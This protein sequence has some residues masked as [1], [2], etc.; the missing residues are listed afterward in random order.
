MDIS[1][2]NA[3]RALVV[4]D[5]HGNLFAWE[6][7][8]LPAFKQSHAD[9]ILQ[10]GDFGYGWDDYYLPRLDELLDEA[11]VEVL[12]LDG[13][14]ENFDR[15]EAIGAFP[16]QTEPQATSRHT[17][18]LPRGFVWTWHGVRCMALGG[19]YSVD[20]D[21][22]TPHRSWWPQEELTDEDVGRACAQGIVQVMFTHDAPFGVQ[23]PG[24]PGPAEE[25]R[26]RELCAPNRTKVRDVQE[27]MMPKTLFAGH[28]HVPYEQRGL[29]NSWVVGLSH[30]DTRGSTAIIDFADGA[31][32]WERI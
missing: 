29:R 8:I 23:V 14:H 26:F 28:M 27:R 15:L 7:T 20:K 25:D 24:L 1:N 16:N 31:H 22:R 18:Y 4:G 5:M 2:L 19:A 30:E 11:G 17:T 12:W 3:S 10:V 21:Y 32:S 13:N 6:R 9:V